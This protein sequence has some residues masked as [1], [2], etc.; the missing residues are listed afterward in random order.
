MYSTRKAF[1]V[2]NSVSS[3]KQL[4]AQTRFHEDEARYFQRDCLENNS[5]YT[6]PGSLGME[7]GPLHD[8]YRRLY[9]S[10]WG[11]NAWLLCC[12]SLVLTVAL[13]PRLKKS[14]STAQAPE[15]MFLSGGL[16][17]AQ[18]EDG[19]RSD[20]RRT[21]SAQRLRSYRDLEPTQTDRDY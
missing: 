18:L 13:S 16:W 20:V 19:S 15:S 1:A 7:K 6:P 17:P 8:Y 14:P 10:N 11:V 21:T 3:C 12:L 2:G 4:F 5:P 9:S